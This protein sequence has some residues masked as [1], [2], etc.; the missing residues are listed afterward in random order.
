MTVAL[1]ISVTRVS[2][3]QIMEEKS[4][5]N[6]NCTNVLLSDCCHLSHQLLKSTRDVLEPERQEEY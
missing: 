1:I 5:G 4:K 6:E 2:T 3:N